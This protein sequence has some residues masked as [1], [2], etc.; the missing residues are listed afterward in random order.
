MIIIVFFL[1]K[2]IVRIWAS[3]SFWASRLC[4]HALI[5]LTKYKYFWPYIIPNA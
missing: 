1:S 2:V 3:N 4:E 5:L